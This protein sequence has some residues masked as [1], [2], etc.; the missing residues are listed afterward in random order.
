MPPPNPTPRRPCVQCN[1]TTKRPNNPRCRLMTCKFAP[2]CYHHTQIRVGQSNIPNGG[3]GVFAKERIRKN[4]I[5]SNMTLGTERM[6]EATFNQRYSNRRATHVVKIGRS[7]Y[8]ATNANKSI[9]GMFNHRD[10]TH[11][12]KNAK[13]QNSGTV[14]TIKAIPAGREICISYGPAYRV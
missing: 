12:P 10:T 3:R 6:D 5:I 1:G 8:D 2:K 11:C 13:L 4:T 9:S 7:Y 14:K